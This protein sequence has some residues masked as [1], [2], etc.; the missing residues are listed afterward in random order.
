MN[1]G[2]YNQRTSQNSY[3]ETFNNAIAEG[4]LNNQRNSQNSHR[5]TI[6]NAVAEGLLNQGAYN[7]RNSQNSHRDTINNAVAEGLLN[8]G[9][10]NNQRENSQALPERISDVVNMNNHF[11]F[12]QNNQ[13]T[14][15]I[16]NAFEA[17]AN[18]RNSYNS[19]DGSSF[20]Q[21]VR[22]VRD[23]VNVY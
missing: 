8:Q 19:Y 17:L 13:Q 7:Q 1:Q 6:N 9:G 14:G 5:D 11:P 2:S 20:G 23:T 4:L 16:N 10:Y 18:D 12:S 22:Q 3:N 15:T 21:D